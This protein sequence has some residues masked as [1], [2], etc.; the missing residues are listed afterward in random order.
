MTFNFKPSI[1][2]FYDSHKA[3][4]KAKDKKELRK[5]KAKALPHWQ[6]I[7]PEEMADAI[8]QIEDKLLRAKVAGIVSF[9]LGEDVTG[10]YFA[11]QPIMKMYPRVTKIEPSEEEVYNVLMDL[12]FDKATAKKMSQVN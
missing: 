4:D 9:E 7:L 1:Q 2:R 8:N 10:I 5:L 11:L 12:G 6:G 3:L